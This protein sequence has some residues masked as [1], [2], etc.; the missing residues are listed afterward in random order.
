[1]VSARASATDVAWGTLMPAASRRRVSFNVS[2]AVAVIER[3][4]EADTPGVARM[5]GI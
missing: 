1:M 3:D 4:H 5:R 2:N